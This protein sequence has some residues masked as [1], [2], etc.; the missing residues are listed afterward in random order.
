MLITE[1]DLT[2]I[3]KN[4]G[5]ET[6][7]RPVK[8]GNW[9]GLLISRDA[10]M[11]YLLIT[12]DRSPIVIEALGGSLLSRKNQYNGVNVRSSFSMGNSNP[13]LGPHNVLNDTLIK[14]ISPVIG[15][16]IVTEDVNFYQF[17]GFVN[18]Q[19]HFLRES[20]IRVEHAIVIY[21]RSIDRLVD[22]AL[23]DEVPKAL[24]V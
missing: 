20:I 18:V 15:C 12:E 1:S 22:Y 11:V 19:L 16:P 2:G 5:Y 24:A 23:A 8:S 10:D 14:R 13:E 6:E 21:E 17:F 3:A 7:K 9:K 4:L